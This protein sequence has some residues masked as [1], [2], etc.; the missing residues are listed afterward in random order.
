MSRISDTTSKLRNW[1]TVVTPERSIIGLI[2]VAVLA[3]AANE[4]TSRIVGMKTKIGE[5]KQYF[6]E[7]LQTESTLVG[8]VS[9]LEGKLKLAA[10][11]CDDEN[12]VTLELKNEVKNRLEINSR[13]QNQIVFLKAQLNE[14]TVLWL[15]RINLQHSNGSKSHEVVLDHVTS[16]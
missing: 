16:C 11:A 5:Y 3:V 7:Q 8:K 15:I 4:A 2:L 1:Y 10:K 12:Q 9:E 6:S 13:L 14:K